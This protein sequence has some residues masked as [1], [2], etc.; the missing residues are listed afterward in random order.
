M[1]DQPL[2]YNHPGTA[3]LTNL[4]SF[5]CTDADATMLRAFTD[6]FPSASIAMRALLSDATVRSVMQRRIRDVTRPA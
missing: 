6:T 1:D 2:P 4:V 5:R 3:T